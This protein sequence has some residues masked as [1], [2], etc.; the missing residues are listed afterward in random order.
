MVDRAAELTA[1][2]ERTA[3]LTVERLDRGIYGRWLAEVADSANAQRSPR[4]LPPDRG[5]HPFRPGRDPSRN[6][7]S[8]S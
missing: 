1:R 8:R 4:H 5:S 3:F 6:E 2:A 7:C